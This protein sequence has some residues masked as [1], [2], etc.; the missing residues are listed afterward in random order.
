VGGVRGAVAV[1][2]TVAT[3]AALLVDGTVRTWGYNVGAQLGNGTLST[4]L[5]PVVVSGLTGVRQIAAGGRPGSRGGHFLAIR[6]DG[7]VWAWGDNGRGQLGDGVVDLPKVP[8]GVIVVG[9]ATAIAGGGRHSLAALSDGSVWAWGWNQAGQLGIGTVSLEER[10][11]LEVTALA[12]M[13]CTAVAGG[14]KHSLALRDDGTVWAWG[15]NDRGQL[16]TGTNDD[17]HVPVE[18][19]GLGG[20]VAI[21]AGGS[22]S[23]A[24]DSAGGV[25]AWGAGDIGQLGQGDWSDSNVPLRVSG[26]ASPAAIASGEQHCLALLP[27]GSGRAWGVGIG[28]ALGNGW[29]RDQNLPVEIL[30]DTT[31]PDQGN[32][33][34]ATRQG[35]DVLLDFALGPAAIWRV[36]SDPDK[37]AIGSTPL[38]PVSDTSA[39]NLVDAGAILRPGDDYYAVRGLSACSETEGP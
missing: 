1:A 20:I 8:V 15:L 5:V 17:S 38:A 10:T 24:L 19:G 11:P 29:Q 32:A 12:G 14:E 6:D 37:A 7:T 26:L 4:S 34:R 21:S 33:L 28:G 18:V 22:S 39:T 25:W 13:T 2:A 23:L 35:S 30:F 16:G 27:D 3:S 31:P 9:G 36:Y